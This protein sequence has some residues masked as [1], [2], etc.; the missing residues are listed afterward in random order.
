MSWEVVIFNS[1]QKI[2]TIEDIDERQL[3]QIDFTEILENSFSEII[4]NDNHRE[5]K[6]PGFSIDFFIDTE[7]VSNKI[8]S[9]Y[10]EKGLFEIIK[11]SKKHGWQIFDIGLGEMVDLENPKN[12]G[13]ENH[14]KYVE[15]IIGKK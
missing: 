6:G 2:E 5:I 9:L 4:K 11:L 10:G 13:F 7:P 15:Q 1:K 8:L 12:N 3:A 14:R